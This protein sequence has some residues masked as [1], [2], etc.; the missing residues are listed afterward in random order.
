MNKEKNNTFEKMD[1][2]IVETFE[3]KRSLL[4]LVNN[5]GVKNKV[6]YFNLIT[7]KDKQVKKYF[8]YGFIFKDGFEIRHVLK[9]YYSAVEA[10]IIEKRERIPQEIIEQQKLF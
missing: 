4:F 6:R 1:S 7:K 10:E 5:I 8:D 9:Q 3:G 2:V